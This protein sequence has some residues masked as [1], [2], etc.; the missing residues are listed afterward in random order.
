MQIFLEVDNRALL[1]RLSFNPVH[2]DMLRVPDLITF[3]IF[4]TGKEI[5]NLL[6]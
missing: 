6:G 4:Q 3:G 2:S 5:K 1:E